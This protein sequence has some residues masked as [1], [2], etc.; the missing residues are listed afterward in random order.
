MLRLLT[1]D[2]TPFDV[3]SAEVEILPDRAAARL[4]LGLPAGALAEVEAAGL[5]HLL[6]E[7]RRR[8][9]S[10]D[11]ARPVRLVVSLAE[12]LLLDVPDDPTEILQAGGALSR[13]DSWYATRLE[14]QQ[15]RWLRRQTVNSRRSGAAACTTGPAAR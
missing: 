6:P 1:P 14:Q 2:G 7:V 3:P 11:P 10:I 13:T 9:P 5:F 15:G 12:D 4:V 8:A